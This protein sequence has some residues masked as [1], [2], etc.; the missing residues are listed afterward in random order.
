[1]IT[2]LADKKTDGI[3]QAVYNKLTETGCDVK[4][5]ALDKMDVKPCYGCGGCSEKTYKRCVVRD[6]ADIILPYVAQSEYVVLIT[7][8]T[9]GSYSFLSK[10]I[11]DKFA[12]LGDVH[13]RSKNGEIVKDIKA[14]CHFKYYV[15]GVDFGVGDTEKQAFERLVCENLLI[16]GWDGKPIVVFSDPISGIDASGVIASEINFSNKNGVQNMSARPGSKSNLR[17][18][19]RVGA[20]DL[21]LKEIFGI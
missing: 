1:M 13:Y 11:V 5:F 18:G 12:M 2:V 14:S 15:A 19:T 8:I 10:R 16:A 7:A 9:Y 21:I 6:D 17:A 4:Y 3:G 20:S